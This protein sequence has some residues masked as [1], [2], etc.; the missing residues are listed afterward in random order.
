MSHILSF[1]LYLFGVYYVKK[2]LEKDVCI[3]FFEFMNKKRAN[4]TLIFLKIY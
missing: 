4:M 1:S 2:I 3:S